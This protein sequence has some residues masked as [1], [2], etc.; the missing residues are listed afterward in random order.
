MR[1]LLLLGLVALAAC[2]TGSSDT[3]P[4]LAGTYTGTAI[5]DI[6]RETFTWTLAES[7]QTVTGISRSVRTHLATGRDTTFSGETVAGQHFHPAVTL[8]VSSATYT[9][10]GF[11]GTAS[12]DGKTLTGTLFGSGYEGLALTLHRQ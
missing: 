5:S 3:L 4:R 1:L 10:Y 7:G 8:S 6:Y 9:D 12:A 11:T 2:D